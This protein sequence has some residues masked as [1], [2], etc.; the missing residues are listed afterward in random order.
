MV[1]VLSLAKYV[2]GAIGLLGDGKVL[3]DART[4][5][6]NGTGDRLGQR[7][8]DSSE[9]VFWRSTKQAHSSP[10]MKL[11]IVKSQEASWQRPSRQYD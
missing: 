11:E 10:S 5:L 8:R 6:D 4:K 7:R 3:A 1:R 2:P 9:A